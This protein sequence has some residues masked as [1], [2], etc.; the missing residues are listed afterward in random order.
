M[1]FGV[2]SLKLLNLDL[3]KYQKYVKNILQQ[4]MMWQYNTPDNE[5]INVVWLRFL[6]ICWKS[7]PTFVVW[8]KYKLKLQWWIS[9]EHFCHLYITEK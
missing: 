1:Q 4:Y 2:F 5:D 7:F 6:V 8:K 3:K 9:R